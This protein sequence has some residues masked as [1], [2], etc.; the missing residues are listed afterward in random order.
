M[1]TFYHGKS[2]AEV[3]EFK[4]KIQGWVVSLLSKDRFKNLQFFIGENMAEGR[5]EGQ[6][7]I[8]EF[9]DEEDGEHPYLMLVK[10]ALIEEK[11]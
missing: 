5:G 3:A 11:C 1:S 8:V 2:E 4:K 9:R 7:A 6:V 10:E